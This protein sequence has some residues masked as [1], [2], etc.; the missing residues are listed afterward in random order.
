MAQTGPS[1]SDETA[2]VSWLASQIAHHSHLYYNLAAPTLSDVE[3]DRLWEEL[4]HLD[5]DHAQLKKVGSD[6]DPG[7]EKVIHQFPMQ[8][9]DKATSD[10]EI[11]HFV[12]ETALG[13]KR[14]LSQPKLDGSALSLEYRKG[15]LVRASTRGSGTRGEDVTRNARRLA[16]VPERLGM[17]VDVH[18][19]GEV[20]MRKDVF[21]Q[22]YR[23][24]SPNPRNLAAGALRQKR[25]EGKAKAEDLVFQ[26][27]D[28]KFPTEDN[29]HP[30]STPPP[31]DAF[32]SDRL[33]WLRDTA[34]IEP[35]P[36]TVHSED[37]AASVAQNMIETTT[38]WGQ[39]REPYAFEIDGVVFKVDALETRDLLGMTAHHPRWSLAW[40]FPPEEATSILLEVTWQTGRTGAVTPVARIA[41]QSV[42]GVTVEHTTLHNVGEVE[43]LG[44]NLGDRV[45]IVRRGDV[46]PKIEASLGPGAA[47][48]LTSRFHADGAPFDEPM[49]TPSPITIPTQCPACDATLIPLGAFI[50]CEN[51]MCDARTSRA[52]L[53]WCRSLEMDGIGE[54]LV[55]QL[56][57]LELIQTIPDLYRLQQAELENIDRMGEK[58]ALN[59][60]IEL[61]KTKSLKLGHFLHA[62]GLPGIGPELATSV[63]QRFTSLSN[64]MLWVSRARAVAGDEEF[65]PEVDEKGKQYADNQAIRSLCEVDGIGS[66]VAFQVRDGLH[67][68]RSMLEDLASMIEVADEPKAAESGPLSGLTLCLTG[69]LE[70]PRKEV[71][72]AIK[73]A[74]GKVVG[75]VSAQ[76]DILVAGEKAGS[77]LTKAETLGVTIWSEKQLH[78]ACKSQPAPPVETP[79]VPAAKKPQQPS[80]FD[81]E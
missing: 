46:I 37:S 39:Q 26:A 29:R 62:L 40:K 57:H 70:R 30:D 3:F 53:Y 33:L 5:P 48:D 56:L 78:D 13:A 41:P 43:R 8:S 21:L 2:R 25:G 50:R 58:S 4:K 11:L 67:Q 49:P 32:D 77:K 73:A 81:Y 1:P 66:K 15:R 12:N 61:G 10:E 55:D 51:M 35:A 63:A 69:S 64:M 65:G 47:S 31:N 42:G 60:I 24:V 22:K 28:A 71:Q 9:L 16:N 6:V 18:V 36:W 52:I 38:K 20:V 75:S 45:L 34:G 27:Y 80:L 14:F 17:D 74:G 7:S 54:K 72:L 23:E 68:R 79:P 59:V 19:R 44:V 76:L